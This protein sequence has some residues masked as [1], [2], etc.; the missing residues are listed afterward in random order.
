M[1]AGMFRKGLRW[2]SNISTLSS[3]GRHSKSTAGQLPRIACMLGRRLSHEFVTT[4]TTNGLPNQSAKRTSL[5]TKSE[6]AA[7]SDKSTI[8]WLHIERR[9]ALSCRNSSRDWPSLSCLN[10]WGSLHV[11]ADKCESN[12]FEI[13]SLWLFAASTQF[14]D[15]K[16]Q[17]VST[18][19]LAQRGGSAKKYLQKIASSTHI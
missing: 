5:Y 13:E 14:N 18:T 17:K 1:T 9:G 16:T 2:Y 8:A 10:T 11:S 4:T 7:V 12:D 3:K 19:N 15:K 6:V